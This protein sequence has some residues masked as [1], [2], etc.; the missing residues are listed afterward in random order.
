MSDDERLAELRKELLELTETGDKHG[1]AANEVFTLLDA[2][3]KEA[4]D[5]RAEC[6]QHLKAAKA[7]QDALSESDSAQMVLTAT[8]T[9]LMRE[10]DEWRTAARAEASLHDETRAERNE[11]AAL[12]AK[13]RE[14]LEG[15]IGPE[16]HTLGCQCGAQWCKQRQSALALTAPAAVEDV[17][18]EAV[19]AFLDRVQ[20]VQAGPNAHAPEPP[21]FDICG[22]CVQVVLAEQREGK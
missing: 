11:Q 4:D 6:E 17:R 14:A 3:R 13:L 22:R 21:L 5:L 15:A 18:R 16:G 8:A 1:Y 7:L 10:R 9:A 12:A 20:A 19:R 2:A